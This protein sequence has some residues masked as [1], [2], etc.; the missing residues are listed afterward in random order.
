V[1]PAA[2]QVARIARSSPDISVT[3]PGG[4]ALDHAALSRLIHRN[5]QA[6]AF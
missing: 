4:I 3:L 2:S 1:A 6:A 5:V